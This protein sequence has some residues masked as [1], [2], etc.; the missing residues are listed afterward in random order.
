MH[1]RKYIVYIYRSALR[2]K[3]WKIVIQNN[4]WNTT[5]GYTKPHVV[6]W[7]ILGCAHSNESHET[8]NQQLKTRRRI[9]NRIICIDKSGITYFFIRLSCLLDLEFKLLIR[10]KNVGNILNLYIYFVF[11]FILII[12]STHLIWTTKLSFAFLLVCLVS[13]HFILSLIVRCS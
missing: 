3:I 5:S 9:H 1:T 2:I 10:L 12:I 11:Y 4:K 8:L 6:Y 13:S 7:N